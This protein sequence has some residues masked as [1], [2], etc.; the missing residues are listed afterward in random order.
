M[1]KLTALLTFVLAF[2]FI[3]TSAYACGMDKAKKSGK[4]SQAMSSVPGH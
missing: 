3:A 2:C 1:R 4:H